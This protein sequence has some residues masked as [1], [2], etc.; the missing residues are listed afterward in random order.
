MLL[1][2]SICWRHI[3]KIFVHIRDKQGSTAIQYYGIEQTR[4]RLTWPWCQASRFSDSTLQN[5]RAAAHNLPSVAWKNLHISTKSAGQLESIAYSSISGLHW[6]GQCTHRSNKLLSP[7]LDQMLPFPYIVCNDVDKSSACTAL[8][9]G[10]AWS[11]SLWPHSCC[12]PS[13][14]ASKAD[15][16][17]H[18][19]MWTRKMLARGALPQHANPNFLNAL[20]ACNCF[21]PLVALTTRVSHA[22]F[23]QAYATAA[24]NA[25]ISYCRQHDKYL[26]LWTVR[27]CCQSKQQLNRNW[28]QGYQLQS[29]LL[30][31][32]YRCPTWSHPNSNAPCANWASG[33]WHC[34]SCLICSSCR[35]WAGSRPN[36]LTCEDQLSWAGALWRRLQ[37]RPAGQFSTFYSGSSTAVFRSCAGSTLFLAVSSRKIISVAFTTI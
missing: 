24:S 11:W 18:R 14:A 36:R 2:M 3:N 16:Q 4:M 20:L 19:H 37:W 15:L 17:A 26:Y 9:S 34:G 23:L 12:S 32:C 6:F 33:A 8:Q 31:V 25:F 7:M 1:D 30:E 13:Q 28:A 10:L 22:I 21:P 27:A 29:H 5:F 35:A